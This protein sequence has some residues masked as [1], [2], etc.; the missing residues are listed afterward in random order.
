MNPKP[1]AIACLILLTSFTAFGAADYVSLQERAQ[2]QSLSGGNVL[3]DSLFNNPAGS[4]F[5]QVY[6]LEANM[7]SLRNFAV[8]ILDTK[9]NGMSGGL[10]YFRR[11][12]GPGGP[13]THGGRVNLSS[14]LSD[15]LGLGVTG[16]YI[17]GYDYGMNATSLTDVDAGLLANFNFM[18]LGLTMR[19][20]FGGNNTMDLARELVLATRFAFQNQLF[21][22]ASATAQY[23]FQPKQV[24][25]GAEYVSPYYFALKSGFYF[26]PNTPLSS[27]TGGL[28]FIS[29][30]LSLHYAIEFPNLG[31]EILHQIGMT[32]LL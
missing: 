28:S 6:A 25:F 15:G 5:T 23:G 21:F 30:K 11:E 24:G 2:G 19:N 3:N 8:S 12:N 4:T 26:V 29:P 1:F 18:Q 27:W 10:A 32:L 13:L 20:L 22:S 14:R 9:N 16:K 7:Q 17:A 31:R